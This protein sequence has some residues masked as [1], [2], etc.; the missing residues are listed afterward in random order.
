YGVESEALPSIV[1]NNFYDNWQVDNPSSPMYRFDHTSHEI[2]VIFDKLDNSRTIASKIFTAL[3]NRKEFMEES[4]IKVERVADKL[5]FTQEYGGL[6]AGSNAYHPQWYDAYDDPT[7]DFVE[8]NPV[9]DVPALGTFTAIKDGTHTEYASDGKINERDGYFGYTMVIRAQKNDGSNAV[10]NMSTVD[11]NIVDTMYTYQACEQTGSNTLASDYA[12]GNGNLV[13]DSVKRI[14]SSQ[15]DINL[16]MDAH[17]DATMA[18]YF[19]MTPY[20]YYQ[21]SNKHTAGPSSNPDWSTYPRFGYQL[22]ASNGSAVEKSTVTFYKIFEAGDSLVGSIERSGVTYVLIGSYSDW[23]DN[24]STIVGVHDFTV[25]TGASIDVI[26]I[27]I[28]WRSSD[29]TRE[30]CGVVAFSGLWFEHESSVADVVLKWYGGQADTVLPLTALPLYPAK[31]WQFKSWDGLLEK[32]DDHV[33]SAADGEILFSGSL[34]QIMIVSK[35]TIDVQQVTVSRANITEDGAF[36]ML[37]QK[38]FNTQTNIL[39]DLYYALGEPGIRET[40]DDWDDVT[41]DSNT[42]CIAATLQDDFMMSEGYDPDYSGDGS[43]YSISY[44]DDDYDPVFGWELFVGDLA[45][46]ALGQVVT[47]ANGATGKIVDFKADTTAGTHTITAVPTNGLSFVAGTL[48]CAAWAASKTITAIPEAVPWYDGNNTEIGYDFD[49]N[50][51]AEYVTLNYS[52]T[53][54]SFA[55][56]MALQQR[57]VG[58]EYRIDVD[59][60]G[61]YDYIRVDYTRVVATP[62]PIAYLVNWST[63]KNDWVMHSWNYVGRKTTYGFTESIDANCDGIFESITDNVDEWPDRPVP[64]EQIPIEVEELPANVVVNNEGGGADSSSLYERSSQCVDEYRTRTFETHYITERYTIYDEY[65]GQFVA[66]QTST[67]IDILTDRTFIY[68]DYD[69]EHEYT[70]AC[71]VMED[72]PVVV[73]SRTHL[74]ESMWVDRHGTLY[75]VD[76]GSGNYGMAYTFTHDSYAYELPVAI[77]I[78]MDYDGD[79]VI[80]TDF[81]YYNTESNAFRDSFFPTSWMTEDPAVDFTEMIHDESWR[82]YLKQ[83][84]TDPMF[85]VRTVINSI[86]QIVIMA[87]TT[88]ASAAATAATAGNPLVG[89]LVAVAVSTGLNYLWSQ[90]SNTLFI[91]LDRAFGGLK[92]KALELVRDD[93]PLPPAL[94]DYG[95]LER[96]Y[97]YTFKEVTAV[98]SAAGLKQDQFWQY[99]DM[100]GVPIEVPIYRPFTTLYEAGET[101][102]DVQYG[103]NPSAEMHEYHD[104][105]RSNGTVEKEV[106]L[107]SIQKPDS[108]GYWKDFPVTLTIDSFQ[109]IGG[110]GTYTYGDTCTFTVT[111]TLRRD[112]SRTDTYTAL[113]YLGFIEFEGQSII[114]P[115]YIYVRG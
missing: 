107:G 111:Y 44:F 37:Y 50:G 17:R 90:L 94:D 53:I 35:T 13:K 76:D 102:Y 115:H 62:Q 82:L 108:S 65:Q 83:L 46:A 5:T 68:Q 23:F 31:A 22:I 15:R 80:S 10:L 114:E 86:A 49:G 59:Q 70:L 77:G 4:G 67:V 113:D 63:T 56:D 104:I 71:I 55:A 38:C 87:L 30:E 42:G 16:V 27:T 96:P 14:A 7:T 3:V 112:P 32:T 29:P 97:P 51:L 91:W 39:Q 52:R 24:Q 28:T 6:I 43:D 92:P 8:S 33:Y 81:S 106:F 57:Y 54:T 64:V 78:A 95:S 73:D 99:G 84:A 26:G 74:P 105:F 48:T 60:D 19:D 11:G 58:N 109:E 25:P 21:L 41:L 61:S 103:R 45:S 40:S 93:V 100:F 79:H 34:K 72:I 66:E 12:D 9:V 20:L 36:G 98:G 2:K 89:L 1:F 47:G 88:V 75:F 110:D 69:G 18:A 85:W 101:S